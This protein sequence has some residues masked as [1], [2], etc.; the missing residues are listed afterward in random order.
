MNISY[1]EDLILSIFPG[2][3]QRFWR[4]LITVA[5]VAI[6]YMGSAQFTLSWLGLGAEA[7]PVWPSAGI[8]LAVLFL[9]GKRLWVGVA[10]GA[11]WLNLSLGASFLVSLGSVIGCTL[12]A[13]V[14]AMGLRCLNFNPTLERLKDAYVLIIFGAIIAPSINATISTVVNCW[15]GFMP[16]HQF[17]LNWGTLWLGDSMGILVF[18][19]LLLLMVQDSPQRIFP[20]NYLPQQILEAVLCWSLLGVLSWLVFQSRTTF[21]LSDYPLEYLPFPFVV[22]AAL[23]FRV[24]GAVLASLIVS[25]MAIGGVLQGIGPFVVKTGSTLGAILLLQTF[26]A[27]VTIT[28]LVLAAA[29]SERQQ[30][31]HQLRATL[32]RD[33]LLAEIALRIRQSLDLDQI[34]Q[35][36]VVE[37]RQLLQA[38]RVYI[39]YLDENNH[40]KI[41]AESVACAYKSL[42]GWKASEKLLQ[43]TQELFAQRQI[44][45]R[46]NTERVN[47]TPYLKDFYRHYQIKATLA[48]PLILD[49][50]LF[51][52]LAVHQCHRS[53]H[54]QSFE[55]DWLRRLAVQVTIAI[56]QAQLYQ[57]VQG[58][59]SNLESQVA[60][61]TL[62]LEEKMQELQRL[63]E[64]KDVFL[65]AVSHDLRTS[66]MGLILMLKGTQN[67]SGETVAL[68]RRI[69]DRLIENSDRQLTLINALS[70]DHFNQGRKIEL[71]CQPLCLN[72]LLSQILADLQ[73]LFSSNH[74]Q[75]TTVIPQTLPPVKADPTQ[76][77]CVFQHLLTN[78]LKHN[79]PGVKI[80]LTVR[81]ERDMLHCAI[82]D[83]GVGMSKQQC[84]RLFKLYVRGLHSQ[85]LTGIGLGLYLCRQIIN[86]HGGQIRVTSV[87]TEGSTF[88]FS[89]P[90]YRGNVGIA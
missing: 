36:T 85:H 84:D 40:S 11:F 17:G 76:L 53:R 33:R 51:G 67:C 64:L 43:E 41:A 4:Y 80:T 22:W 47:V 86:A 9:Q 12:Q 87:P 24:W 8:A 35:T 58:L 21:A 13:V 55:V 34:L 90:F 25:G 7:S 27:V 29:M 69:L 39:S 63:Y 5:L 31:E 30:A 81:V 77:R 72:E 16:W 66:M 74:A 20:P 56:Q 82:A 26:M 88:N 54:W 75:L 14:G 79:L 57:Q 70:E 71:H 23:R 48:I 50:Q 52:L 78:A 19:P 1:G 3:P 45:I 44:L 73:P 6:A 89:L 38:D 65:Q 10:I 15:V 49:D 60:E 37:V 59:N 42:L 61:R 32:E 46:D 2:N 28:A 18:T 62:Q 68:P 83:N